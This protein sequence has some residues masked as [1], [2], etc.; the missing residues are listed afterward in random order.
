MRRKRRTHS[1]GFK[2]K[3][4]LA[5]I[6]GGLTT[7]E[8]V[9]KFDVHADQI[10]EWKEQLLNGAADVFG[11]GRSARHKYPTYARPQDSVVSWETE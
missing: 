11:K 2:S 9:K 1:P 7:A 3:V 10:T 5:V 8:T 4:A 6:Q